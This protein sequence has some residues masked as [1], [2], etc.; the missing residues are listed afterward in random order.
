MCSFCNCADT[1]ARIINM[2]KMFFTDEPINDLNDDLL[3]RSKF[4]NELAKSFLSYHDTYPLCVGLYGPWGSGKTSLLNLIINSIENNQQGFTKEENPIILKFNPWNYTSTNQLFEQYFMMLSNQLSS[5]ANK[6]LRAISKMINEYSSILDL[7]P[8]GKSVR[9]ILDLIAMRI[10]KH[11][12]EG[13]SIEEQKNK[14]VEY[15]NETSNKIIVTIDDIDRLSNKDI[16][17]IFKLISTVA[18]FPNT[19]FILSFDKEIVAKALN[20][21]QNDGEK[22]LEK[23]IQVLIAVP[24]ATDTQLEKIFASYFNPFIKDYKGLIFSQNYWERMSRYVFHMIV[25]VRDIVR[26]ANTVR[27]K[28]NMIGNEIN[29]VDLLMITVIE[30]KEPK[31]YKWIKNHKYDLLNFYHDRMYLLINNENVSNIAKKYFDN[32]IN[33]L[34]TGISNE[35]CNEILILLFPLYASITKQSVEVIDEPEL[36]K[37]QRLGHENK[38]DRYFVLDIGE[39]T[40]ARDYLKNALECKDTHN[41][42]LFLE[43]AFNSYDKRNLIREISALSS[44]L[45]MDRSKTLLEASLSCMK[46]VENNESSG[47]FMPSNLRNTENLCIDLMKKIDKGNSFSIFKRVLKKSNLLDLECFADM[48]R[49]LLNAYEVGSIDTFLQVLDIKQLKELCNCYID[50][51]LEVGK[52]ENFL[53]LNFSKT[54]M[55]IKR[56]DMEKYVKYLN[57][58][59]NESDLNKLRYLSFTIGCFEGNSGTTYMDDDA[60][61][62]EEIISEKEINKVVKKSIDDGEIKQLNEEQILHIAAYILLQDKNF[63][64]NNKKGVSE[65]EC[66]EKIKGW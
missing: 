61:D 18:D 41:L 21:Y 6:K 16:R 40:I 27:L 25:N 11:T 46:L 59:F 26:L 58:K 10:R 36:I 29:F 56:L 62:R 43:N 33:N 28:L 15:L 64:T 24:P 4:A 60:K 1:H 44:D 57:S 30:L 20:Q 5:S 48:F 14:I 3:S 22:Y 17:M 9:K 45:S 32:E 52:K 23:I 34:E 37:E 2:N 38:F 7:L 50:R 49:R 51:A 66:K 31:F 65:E 55:L 42:I 53:E 8:E 39:N 13:R 12:L 54:L 63:R 35:E 19:I 47:F